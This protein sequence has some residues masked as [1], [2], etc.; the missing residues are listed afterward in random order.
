VKRRIVLAA[1]AACALTLGCGSSGVI[2]THE[3]YE[4]LPRDYRQE[5]F[6]AEN[7]LVIARSSQDEAEDRK[8]GAERALDDLA[9][10]WRRTT[11]RLGSSGAAKIAGA[12]AVY[13]SHVA[14]AE[15]LVDV[16][17]AAVRRTA[18]DVRLSRGRL[19]LVRQRQLAR[20]GRATIASL[21]PLEDAVTDL[22][23]RSKAAL[24]DE[25]GVR[26][27]VQTQLGAWKAAEDRYVAASGDYDTGVWGD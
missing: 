10:T 12:K 25:L 23:N 1:L 22:E 24:A 9:R 14:Y 6:D 18:A 8:A 4:R 17:E 15:A 11:Q 27:R 19:Y 5:I 3:E 16:A 20:I 26:V 21:K 7:D 13:E 2:L